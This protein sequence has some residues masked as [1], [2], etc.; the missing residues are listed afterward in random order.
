[1]VSVTQYLTLEDIDLTVSVA[2]TVLDNINDFKF[3]N[4][5]DLHELNI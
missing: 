2:E 5:K 1:M 3:K 4:I